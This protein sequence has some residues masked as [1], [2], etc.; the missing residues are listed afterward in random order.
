M[1]DCY[2]MKHTGFISL[3]VM[4]LSILYFLWCDTS[5]ILIIFGIYAIICIE[6]LRANH[7]MQKSDIKVMQAYLDKKLLLKIIQDISLNYND[8]HL[9]INA[10]L[11]NIIKYFILNMVE[12]YFIDSNKSYHKISSLGRT[13]NIVHVITSYIQDLDIQESFSKFNISNV[14][15]LNNKD[16]LQMELF[17]CALFPQIIHNKTKSIKNAGFILIT[18]DKKA[19]LYLS[20]SDLDILDE[21]LPVIAW[22]AYETVS[23]NS[24]KTL[25]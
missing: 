22:E 2:K 19:G 5:H 4:S 24:K 3:M 20:K 7:I 6:Y 1:E 11:N 16:V 17:N 12:V 9:R 8:S 13:N 25:D 23:L 14:F 18:I 10:L 21:I 15:D